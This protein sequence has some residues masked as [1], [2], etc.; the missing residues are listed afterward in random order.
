[1]DHKREHRTPSTSKGHGSG[2]ENNNMIRLQKAQLTAKPV[3]T[4]ICKKT[5]Q[6]LGFMIK[7]NGIIM[8]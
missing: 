3:K 5:V 1:M 8:Q 4:I 6:Y 2:V 7:K